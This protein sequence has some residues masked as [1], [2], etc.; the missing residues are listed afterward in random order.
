V[1]FDTYRLRFASLSSPSNIDIATIYAKLPLQLYSLGDMAEKPQPFSVPYASKV[2][3]IDHVDMTRQLEG[4]MRNL[5]TSYDRGRLGAEIAYTVATEKLGLKG[6]IMHEPSVGGNDLENP[7]GTAIIQARMLA[8]TNDPTADINAK[9]RSDLSQMTTKLHD[10]FKIYPQATG[11]AILTYA[12]QN[13]TN[14]VI[15]VEVHP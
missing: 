3:Q 9:L 11:Y 12:D 8:S 1:S 6:L 13:D 5:G 10:G 7:D 2:F 15:I 4:E 14:R